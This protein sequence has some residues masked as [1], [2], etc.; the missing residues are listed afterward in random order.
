MAGD[1]DLK[2][3]VSDKLMSI[4]NFS[5]ATVIQYVIGLAKQASSASDLNT[6]LVE[7]AN[8]PS[9]TETRKFAQELFA[10]APRKSS[11]LNSYQ[12]E[13]K[14]A[15]MSVRKQQTYTLLEPDSD[16][17]D[18]GVQKLPSPKKVDSHKKSFRKKIEN[19]DD[20][21]DE[22]MAEPVK[23]KRV[24]RKASYDEDDL[25][26][27]EARLRDQEE[28]KQLEKN[29]RERDAA[30]TRKLTEQKLSRREEEEAIRRSKAME[31]D[32]TE[33]LRVVSRQEYLKKRE[34][35]KLEEIRYKRYNST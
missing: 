14:E 20:D 25:E 26:S 4:V 21:D 28:R 33:A 7:F 11:G 13:E 35:K 30:G 23:E 15:A 12:R 9:T 6:K 24:K 22:V 3:W 29:L 1:G 10:R 18:I 27:E 16:E 8:L 34:Q 19:Q 5:Q 17:D 31:K 2:I 32:D